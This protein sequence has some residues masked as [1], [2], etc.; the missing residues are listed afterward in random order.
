MRLKII[1]IIITLI[2][3]K[4]HASLP[5]GYD[6]HPGLDVVC[7]G[8]A[9]SMVAIS[10]VNIYSRAATAIFAGK[11]VYDITTEGTYSASAKCS[12]RF[13]DWNNYYLENPVSYDEFVRDRCYG[14]PLNCPGGL[15]IGAPSDCSSFIVCSDYSSIQNQPFSFNDMV[16]PFAILETQVYYNNWAILT[17]SPPN[18]IP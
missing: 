13:Q 1:F 10:A 9:L 16:A 7:K 18:F 4:S 15:N 5:P 14:N 2:S 3:V 6:H 12:M 8:L 17:E 11:E